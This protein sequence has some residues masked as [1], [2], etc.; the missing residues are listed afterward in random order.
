MRVKVKLLN[1]LRDYAPEGDHVFHLDLNQGDTV[2]RVI[3]ALKIPSEV[4]RI[5]LVNGRRVDEHTPL[6]AE[7]TVV[8]LSPIFGG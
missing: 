1:A 5:I 7:D 4:D 8:F 2:D 3:A 6:R